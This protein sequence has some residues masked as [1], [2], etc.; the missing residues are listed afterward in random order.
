[1]ENNII[2]DDVSYYERYLQEKYNEKE[3]E[4]YQK[5]FYNNLSQKNIE[6]TEFLCFI[7]EQTEWE[8][9]LIIIKQ[10]EWDRF[11]DSEDIYLWLEF[12]WIVGVSVGVG[13]TRTI[14]LGSMGFDGI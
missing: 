8:N 6:Y 12:W 11:W 5:E 7:L 13:L 3:C 9:D 1:M 10:G 14:G 2:Q 4:Q